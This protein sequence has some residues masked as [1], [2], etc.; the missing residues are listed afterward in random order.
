M[1]NHSDF[2]FSFK[3]MAIKDYFLQGI[4]T[5]H[6]GQ[7]ETLHRQLHWVLRISVA[8]CFIGHGTWGIITKA[9]WLPFFARPL[10]L[11]IVKERDP[12]RRAEQCPD[13]LVLK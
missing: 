7:L 11:P 5:K 3:S 12:L 13:E 10:V 2:S 8:L 1:F 9:G 6:D 4:F